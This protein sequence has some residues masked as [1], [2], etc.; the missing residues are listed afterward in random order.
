MPVN[1]DYLRSRPDAIRG[2]GWSG[3]S[4]PTPAW[5]RPEPHNPGIATDGAFGLRSVML[6]YM[7]HWV[8][9]YNKNFFVHGLLP[10]WFYGHIAMI[11]VRRVEVQRKSK[12]FHIE[13]GMRR[14]RQPLLMIHGEAD[15]YIKTGMA[16]TL[17][18][19]ARGP[20]D[21]WA[22]PGARHNQSIALAGEEYSRRVVAFF[23][24]YLR[25]EAG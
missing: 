16:R 5:Q 20:K 24:Q 2:I 25:A 11:G 12:Y 7:R 1:I 19:L 22:V 6:P 23:D 17:F 15:S 8:S 13:P 9:V 3:V 14:L 18:Q 21:F 4:R 10:A